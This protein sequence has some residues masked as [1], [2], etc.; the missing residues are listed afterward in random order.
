MKGHTGWARPPSAP[1]TTPATAFPERDA[2][3]L[4]ALL[5]AR[6]GEL[7]GTNRYDWDEPAIYSTVRLLDWL[8]PPWRAGSRNTAAQLR[9]AGL[10]W[11]RCEGLIGERPAQDPD[12]GRDPDGPQ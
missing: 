11:L 12:E 4:C 9:N 2:A 10:R 5:K 8:D 7:V 3:Y 6:L 1:S